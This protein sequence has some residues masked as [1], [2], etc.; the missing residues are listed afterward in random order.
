MSSDFQHLQ[1]LPRELQLMV[2]EEFIRA[3]QEP[4]IV[5]LDVEDCEALDYDYHADE[6]VP[7]LG[8][9]LRVDNRE[10]LHSES[11]AVVARRLLAVCSTSRQVA[12][13]FLDRPDPVAQAPE[14]CEALMGLGLS[15]DDDIF[16]LPDDLPRYRE[17]RLRPAAVRNSWD[18][19]RITSIM[20]SLDAFEERLHWAQKSWSGHERVSRADVTLKFTLAGIFTAYLG[21]QRLIIMVDTPRQHVSWDQIRIVKA[22]DRALFGVSDEH[23]SARYNSAFDNYEALR[24]QHMETRSPCMPTYHLNRRPWPELY[25]AFPR[26]S[27]SNAT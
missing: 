25:F 8:W 5:L 26:R 15:L 3:A 27:S 24:R 2:F 19:H 1:R 4:S 17:V 6:M 22:N 13:R 12:K 10:Q 7:V 21:A 16:R 23:G 11:P 20:I 14:H 18:E 9:Q